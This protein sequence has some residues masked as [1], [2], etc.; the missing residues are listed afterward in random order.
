LDI[1][2][3]S[4]RDK[5]AAARFFRKSLRGL[6]YVPS[7]VITDQLKSY[8]AA[9]AE[10]LPGVEHHR[11]KGRNNRAENSHQPT[12]VRE[13]VMRRFKSAGQA[14]AVSFRLQPYLL[15]FPSRKAPVFSGRLAGSDEVKICPM[16]RGVLC[17]GSS[18]KGA[19]R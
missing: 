13:K 17:S 18:V 19:I 2:V 9:K 6:Q 11:D 4:R 3:Q 1:L 10:I 16:E 8:G 12:R 7:V 5:R 14:R 15:T